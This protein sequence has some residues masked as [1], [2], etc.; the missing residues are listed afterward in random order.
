MS[1]EDESS[2]PPLP[3]STGAEKEQ[4]N[5]RVKRESDAKQYKQSWQTNLEEERGSTWR[6]RTS[7]GRAGN[8][9]WLSRTS[10]KSLELRIRKQ[11]V[12]STIIVSGLANSQQFLSKAKGQIPLVETLCKVSGPAGENFQWP[13]VA[14][15][16]KLSVSSQD[17][18]G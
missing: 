10:I 5:A 13:A 12:V 16:T 17:K 4:G 18:I 14:A 3:Q 15:S 11:P 7:R 6:S 1:G 8:R 9:N 2:C